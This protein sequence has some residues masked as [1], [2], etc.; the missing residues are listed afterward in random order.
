[1]ISTT[2]SDVSFLVIGLNRMRWFGF[3]IQFNCKLGFIVSKSGK[4]EGEKKKRE[5]KK[6]ERKRKRRR[7]KREERKR[8]PLT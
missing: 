2:I 3:G 4:K 8:E 5:R 6:K 7:E 1:M